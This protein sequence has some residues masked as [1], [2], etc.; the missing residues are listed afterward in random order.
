M[1]RYNPLPIEEITYR[2]L[3]FDFNVTLGFEM[4]GN[5]IF[6]LSLLFLEE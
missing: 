2:R 6:V 1:I 4:E 3:C 5:H